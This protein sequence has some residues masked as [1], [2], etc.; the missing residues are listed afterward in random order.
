MN[1]EEIETKNKAI[2]HKDNSLNRLDLSFIKHIELNEY[3]K[4]ELLAYWIHDYAVYHDEERTF[5]ISKSGVFQRGEVIK[6]NLGFNIGN[7]LGGMHYCVVLSKYD[8]TR[9]GAL[10]VIPLTSKKANKRYDYSCVNLGDELYTIFL[11]KIKKKKQKLQQI[12]DRL[13]RIEDIPLRIK[14]EM[15]KE[16][17]YI[18]TMQNQIEKLKQDSIVL[19]NQITTISKQRIFY[20]DVFKKIRISNNS[21]DLIDKQVI[22]SFTK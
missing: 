1:N 4:S 21:L 11:D 9:N 16:K 3:K 14:K 20:D 13:D 19:I 12:M 10:N 2:V 15:D 18:E 5:D 8:N 17:V 7:E 22:K 6:V